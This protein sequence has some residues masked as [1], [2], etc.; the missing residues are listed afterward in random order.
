MT[1]P[2]AKELDLVF[3]CFPISRKTIEELSCT[4]KTIQQNIT[5]FAVDWLN[6]L[7]LDWTQTTDARNEASIGIAKDLHRIEAAREVLE[8]P[9]PFI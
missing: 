6:Y 3:N 4:H 1:D 5:R 7:A 9:I 2:K 8:R